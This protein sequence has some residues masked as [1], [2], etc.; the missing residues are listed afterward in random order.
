MNHITLDTA[1]LALQSTIRDAMHNAKIAG[2]QRIGF[3]GP[4]VQQY[5]QVQAIA[6]PLQTLQG[7]VAAMQYADISAALELIQTRCDALRDA[8]PDSVV[9]EVGE[10]LDRRGS[11]PESSPWLALEQSIRG[12]VMHATSAAEMQADMGWRDAA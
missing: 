6:G 10:Y 2:Q 9:D 4:A 11:Y 12:A 7:A 5:Q 1:A 3:G 8:I